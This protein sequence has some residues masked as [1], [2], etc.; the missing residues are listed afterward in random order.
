[1]QNTALKNLVIWLIV[2]LIGF[3]VF[4]A[5]IVLPIDMMNGGGAMIMIGLTVAISSPIIAFLY[6]HRA[7]VFTSLMDEKNLLAHWYYNP[8]E[9]KIFAE[10]ESKFRYAGQRWLQII[11]IFF[12][13]LIGGIFWWADPETGPIIALVLLIVN[14]IIALIVF[15]NNR[16][17]SKWKD[18]TQVDCRINTNGLII[19]Q[20]LHIWTGWGMKMENAR[21]N[22]GRQNLLEIVY[23]SPNRYS[24]QYTTVRMLIPKGKE[25]IAQEIVD[26]LML[27]SS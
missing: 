8:E 9:W 5:P 11:V 14:L 19:N 27:Q 6:Y 26:K 17:M 3:M 18:A 15:L 16:S 13:L 22:L 2:G 7:R 21:V 1:M 12:S 4:L 23:S 10:D 25:S 20:E 24:R